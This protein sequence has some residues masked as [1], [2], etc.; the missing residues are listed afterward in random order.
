M[1]DDF[2][3]YLDGPYKSNSEPFAGA[4]AAIIVSIVFYVV[5][6]GIIFLCLAL[7]SGS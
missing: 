5:L 6:F 4:I 1:N 3:P 2:P 7:M